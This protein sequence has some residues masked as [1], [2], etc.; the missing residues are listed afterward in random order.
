MQEEGQAEAVLGS[1][2]PH[3]SVTAAEDHMVIGSTQKETVRLREP[4]V[5]VY[6]VLYLFAGEDRKNATS[7]NARRSYFKHWQHAQKLPS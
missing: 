3:N 5:V 4:G 7:P 6:L 1:T 2:L